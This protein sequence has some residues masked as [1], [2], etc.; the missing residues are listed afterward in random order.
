MK[1]YSLLI[2]CVLLILGMVSCAATQVKKITVEAES[3]ELT[4]EE[5]DMQRLAET[6][7]ESPQTHVVSVLQPDVSS[8]VPTSDAFRTN[9]FQFGPEAVPFIVSLPNNTD[10]EINAV[11]WLCG[12]G[13]EKTNV[14]NLRTYPDIYK[15][16]YMIA[17]MPY[18]F[19]SNS[20]RVKDIKNSVGDI[21]DY[22]KDI[23]EAHQINL[24]RI[25]LVGYS[26]GHL[27]MAYL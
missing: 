17:V 16:K 21:V 18:E 13:T 15:E 19:K 23:A 1:K 11:I 27:S 10:Q 14:F 9:Y 3:V 8:S 22:V 2:L 26:I 5:V 20:I 7:N 24:N 4:P 25:I 6:F 12:K